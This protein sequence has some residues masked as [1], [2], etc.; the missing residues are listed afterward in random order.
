MLAK[1]EPDLPA[2]QKLPPEEV[3][4]FDEEEPDETEAAGRGP[5]RLAR[6]LLG[7]GSGG[8]LGLVVAGLLG[9]GQEGGNV[10]FGVMAG[11]VALLA[12]AMAVL[13]ARQKDAARPAPPRAV[14]A[15]VVSAGALLLTQ[16]VYL[17]QAAFIDSLTENGQEV[18]LPL[19]VWPVSSKMLWTA[20]LLAAA[21]FILGLLGWAESAHERGKYS[22]GKWVAHAILAGGA[23]VGLGLACYLMGYGVSLGGE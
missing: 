6:L 2:A 19:A 3:P 10:S 16:T 21:G 20:G 11:L 5:E 4:I 13:S 1:P 18:R 23:T 12:A 9:T 14:W 15:A 7:A 17:L 8:V 22:G